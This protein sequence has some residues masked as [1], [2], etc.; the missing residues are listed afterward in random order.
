MDVRLLLPGAI[1]AGL[2]AAGGL[3]LFGLRDASVGVPKRA[4]QTRH[5][6]RT[7]ADLVAANYKVLSPVQSRRLIRFADEFA[8]CVVGKGVALGAPK[9]SPTKIVMR[10]P[11]SVTT[12][13]IGQVTLTCAESL[14]GPPKDA[15][16]V[17]PKS[18][19]TIELYLPKRCL[20]DRKT[21]SG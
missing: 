19:Q 5:E 11:G 6:P 2:V 21:A 3:W 8:A 12:T 16:L 20:L 15:S 1:V 17:Q 14:G 10:L 18:G 9:P 7:Y 13:R 4:G